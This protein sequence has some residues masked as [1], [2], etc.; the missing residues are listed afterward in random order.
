M[1]NAILM[2]ALATSFLPLDQASTEAPAL[3]EAETSVLAQAVNQAAYNPLCQTIQLDSSYNATLNTNGG[4]CVHFSVTEP[5]KIT[6]IMAQLDAATDASLK[7]YHHTNGQFKQIGTE[8]VAAGTGSEVLHSLNQPGEYYWQITVNKATNDATLFGSITTKHFDEHEVNDTFETSTPFLNGWHSVTANMDTGIDADYFLYKA[9]STDGIKL[10]LDDQLAPNSWTLEVLRVNANNW[11]EYQGGV[12]HLI[13]GLAK[14]EQMLVRVTA[15][16][17]ATATTESYA[18]SVGAPKVVSP[19]YKYAP[20][21]FSGS[22]S[23]QGRVNKNTY[24][25]AASPYDTLKSFV[26]M[27]RSDISPS[28]NCRIRLYD[29]TNTQIGMYGCDRPR[30]VNFSEMNEYQKPIRAHLEMY[31]ADFADRSTVYYNIGLNASFNYIED[32]DND[33]MPKSFE[34]KYGLNDL[35]ALDAAL[36]TDG[37]GVTNLKEYQA[38]TDPTDPLNK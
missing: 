3:L 37:D 24:F 1:I 14:D 19:D 23:L 30:Q 8:S 36:D 25:N 13:L 7:L 38:E 22:V 12:E 32:L 9:N 11:V 34:T 10:F 35:T 26:I 29:A 15:N 2:S 31:H 21:N 27:P 6:S 16:P 4:V 20:G 28:L 5:T 17:A 33:G 18:L